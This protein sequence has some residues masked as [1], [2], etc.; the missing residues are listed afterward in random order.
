MVRTGSAVCSAATPDPECVTQRQ[1]D[2][3]NVMKLEEI[4]AKLRNRV[5]ELEVSDKR[6]REEIREK[7]TANTS[8]R[9]TINA[10]ESTLIQMEDELHRVEKRRLETV[11]CAVEA[12][13]TMHERS[14][15]IVMNCVQCSSKDERIETLQ[16]QADRSLR[17]AKEAERL[18]EQVSAL[19]GERDLLKSEIKRLK[20]SQ[21]SERIKIV[22]KENDKLKAISRAN[23]SPLVNPSDIKL[24]RV[25]EQWHRRLEALRAQH[26]SVRDDY[27]RTILSLTASRK[28]L[29]SI[30]VP[31]SPGIASSR[32]SSPRTCHNRETEV[33]RGRVRDLENRIESVKQ[34]Y[35]LK[36]RKKQDKAIE[37][38]NRNCFRSVS[39]YIGALI[40]SNTPQSHQHSDYTDC[41]PLPEIDTPV[42]EWMDLLRACICARNRQDLANELIEADYRRVSLVDKRTF[43]RALGQNLDPTAAKTLAAIYYFGE[44]Q[45]DY[46]TFLSDL[47]TRC[48]IHSV[49]LEVEN[50]ALR[51]HVARL[52]GELQE[53]IEILEND[54]CLEESKKE[55]ERKNHQ[56]N[57]YKLELERVRTNSRRSATISIG[58]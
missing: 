1:S 33:L 49:D 23:E 26:E 35:S 44:D 16:G 58:A 37:R 57:I 38:P 12:N 52:M 15:D 34:Y 21:N 47:A 41:P 31:C 28:K 5:D 10:H 46:K 3:A 54:G 43:L 25:E 27:E 29:D 4:C 55:L 13:P 40:L 20:A 2:W 51:D 18:G 36:L 42:S 50:A 8:L 30:S 48:G 9:Q 45:V 24:R 22:L 7:E 6:L 56:L 11:S 53:K 14:V 17:S 39:R 19:L 32:P